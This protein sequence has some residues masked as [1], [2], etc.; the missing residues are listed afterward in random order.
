MQYS[1]LV[2][3]GRE[4]MKED[5]RRRFDRRLREAGLARICVWIPVEDIERLKEIAKKLREAK[6]C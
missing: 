4:K 1:R 5:R 3:F 2:F 6:S